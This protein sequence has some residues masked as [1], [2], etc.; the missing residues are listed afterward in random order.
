MK[1]I[2]DTMAYEAETPVSMVNRHFESRDEYLDYVNSPNNELICAIETNKCENVTDYVVEGGK[3]LIGLCIVGGIVGIIHD[4]GT[5][6]KG[7][8]GIKNFFRAKSLEKKIKKYFKKNPDVSLEET[9]DFLSTLGID[10]EEEIQEIIK[11]YKG[12]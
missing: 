9:K 4:A 1:K 11:C 2:F 12:A 7:I 8:R 3:T 10:D 6:F 5:G